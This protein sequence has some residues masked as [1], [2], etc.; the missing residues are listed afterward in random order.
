MQFID[1]KLDMIAQ[2]QNIPPPPP[3]PP[4]K[5]PKKKCDILNVDYKKEK[6]LQNMNDGEQHLSTD[7]ENGF[8][9][10]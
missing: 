9:H 4:K 8:A 5:K 3:P 7:F 6:Y 10:H 1:T 2:I